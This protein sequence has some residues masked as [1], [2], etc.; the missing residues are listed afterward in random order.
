M[1]QGEIRIV[2]NRR[3]TGDVE[4]YRFKEHE[5]RVDSQTRR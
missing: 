3:E 1:T 5:K 4:E 2:T